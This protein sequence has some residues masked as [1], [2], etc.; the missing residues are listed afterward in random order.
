[1]LA[2]RA[3]VLTKLGKG[4]VRRYY[5]WQH[6][7][8][9]RIVFIV[10]RED[11]LLT[12]FCVVGAFHDALYGYLRSNAPQIMLALLVRPHLWFSATIAEA[13]RRGLH[14]FRWKHRSRQLEPARS[15]SIRDMHMRST[16]VEQDD[17]SDYILSIAVDPAYQGG[18]I[19]RE[20]MTCAEQVAL[21]R[22]RR[23][24]ALSVR[25]ENSAAIAF[26][27]SRGYA[28]LMKHNRW[29]GDMIKVFH[30]SCRNQ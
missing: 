15:A 22:G 12:G 27:I 8:Q 11:G 16:S 30:A 1:M 19:G 14:L 4:V 26:Y 10:C 20:L 25:E 5:Q 7:H 29:N 2:F 28:K 9:R 6:E 21:L 24:L 18:G 17:S 3:S 13:V 23:A